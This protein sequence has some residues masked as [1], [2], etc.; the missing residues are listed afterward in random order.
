MRKSREEAAETRERIV[1]TA[2]HE[3]G[4]HGIAETGLAD[5]MAAVGLTHGG[6]YKHFE[7]KGQLV[8][9]AIE[10]SMDSQRLS[11]EKA[12]G[13]EAL[14]AIVKVYVSSTH[15]DN[16]EEVCPVAALGSELHRADER[17]RDAAS[18][19]IVRLI[20]LIE[21]RLTYLSPKE[22]KSRAHAILAAMVGSVVLSRIVMSPKLSDS[23]LR[24]TREFILQT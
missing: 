1:D 2:A 6:F 13:D 18:R 5:V 3:F 15:R 11:M 14:E 19:G 17:T 23:L 16:T 22:A 8:A 20:S 4:Q 21:S 24:D 12:K 9:E 7:S 10:K